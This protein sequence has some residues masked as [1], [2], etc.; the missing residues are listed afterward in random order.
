M[1]PT[2]LCPACLALLRDPV[3]LK[4]GHNM[5]REC[6]NTLG[7]ANLGV[8]KL[9]DVP[10]RDKKIPGAVINCPMCGTPTPLNGVVDNVALRNFLDSIRPTLERSGS[11]SAAASAASSSDE[12]D[13]APICGF[14]KLPATK[15]CRMC[16]AL[17]EEH[18]AMLH[19]QGP[20]AEH[21]LHST[22]VPM[23]VSVEEA[24]DVEAMSVV[25]GIPAAEIA[26][27]LCGEHNR[28]LKL[29]CMQCD[30]IICSH[31]A[32]YG[33]HK[34]HKTEYLSRTFSSD[35]G[36]MEEL[37]KK[38]EETMKEVEAVAPS[39]S[40]ESSE[41]E[42]EKSIAKLHEIYASL[43]EYLRVSEKNSLDEVDA[44]FR[45]FDDEVRQRIISCHEIEREANS[46]LASTERVAVVSDLTKYLLYQ[47]LLN[48]NKELKRLST[49]KV[50]ELKA[51]VKIEPQT[52][53]EQKM[54]VCTLRNHLQA[55]DRALVF[56]E[57]NKQH[58]LD[59][60]SVSSD[61]AF[62]M[63]AVNGGSVYVPERNLI[64]SNSDETK[65]GRSV[66]FTTFRNTT[67]VSKDL[68]HD[69]ISFRCGG[70][71]PAFDGHDYVYFFQN[72][73]GAN[74]K[75][76][77]LDLNT[78][79]F[80]MLASIP[81]GSFLPHTSAAANPQHVYA[82]DNKMGIWDYCVDLDTWTDTHIR[83]DQP[84]RLFFDPVDL[85]TIVAF[86][87][88]EEGIYSVD[89]EAGTKEKISSPPKPFSLRTNRDA[90][91]A[92]ISHE[93]F[94]MFAF[95]SDGWYLFDSA[96]KSWSKFENWDN[97]AKDSSSFFIEPATRIAFYAVSG[98]RNL[99]MV[100]LSGV[101]V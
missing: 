47:S 42:K 94:L 86:C 99:H 49:L 60:F 101:R 26:I 69:I 93:Q 91:L 44:V 89:V 37:C 10:R 29:Y 85:D 62:T 57:L 33:E 61:V 39:F 82:M 9:S 72:G 11:S 98:G 54:R 59:T 36:S 81:N 50:P 64:V 18:S 31:C 68:K 70:M 1:E 38:V 87:G 48:L 27:P 75:F 21:Q 77:R 84:A 14:C 17:C 12:P 43:K 5:C 16:G 23:F 73:E 52:G 74:N 58:I 6:A 100:E 35:N 79:S 51:I 2:T 28:P 83:L 46:V 56:F 67:T 20:F 24:K 71:Y 25:N 34:G 53:I 97:P 63:P 40:V 15:F 76:G 8:E 32:S 41:S 4:C 22:P 19:V 7:Q 88:E 78:R 95:L 90:F 92:R 96:D 3:L 66:L 80:E 65:H 30:K 45:Q 13:V 55:G